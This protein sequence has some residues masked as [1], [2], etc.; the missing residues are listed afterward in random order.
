MILNNKV[1]K[2]VLFSVLFSNYF[3]FCMVEPTQRLVV[4]NNSRWS[5]S[6]NNKDL[7][8][9]N[10]S[11]TPILLPNQIT[12]SLYGEYWS[13]VARPL[14]IDIPKELASRG[15]V[16][17]SVSDND[18][19]ISVNVSAL[20]SI[21]YGIEIK[22]PEETYTA[23]TAELPI[24]NNPWDAFP[25]VKSHFDAQWY[26]PRGYRKSMDYVRYL[27]WAYPR[28]LARYVLGLPKEYDRRNVSTQFK[29]LSLTWHP[30][31]HR[32]NPVAAQ[33]FKI[34]G[35]AKDI[36]QSEPGQGNFEEYLE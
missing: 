31:K 24:T 26:N 16:F 22:T 30:D 11:I 6:V 4:I 5:I 18:V 28:D 33:I 23:T 13:Q 35:Q 7:L 1:I 20:G 27:N 19:I 15:F 2:F 36:L 17:D 14:R 3:T 8:R 32:G 25:A 34:L 21:S 9:P 12:I 29:L 10:Q